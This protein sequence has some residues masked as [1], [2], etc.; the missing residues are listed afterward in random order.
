MAVCQSALHT[1]ASPLFS[2][3]GLL[4]S[5]ERASMDSYRAPSTS[6]GDCN[7]GQNFFFSSPKPTKTITNRIQFLWPN[8]KSEVI[9]VSKTLSNLS[10][11]PP[12]SPTFRGKKIKIS[13]SCLEQYMLH[14][15]SYSNYFSHCNRYIYFCIRRYLRYCEVL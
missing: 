12:K 1:S 2:S 8:Q 10:L 7:H 11:K 5:C 4:M 14:H 13:S 15:V 3:Q 6:Q 9:H